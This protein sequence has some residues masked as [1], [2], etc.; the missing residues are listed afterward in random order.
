MMTIIAIKM[1]ELSSGNQYGRRLSRDSS[2]AGFLSKGGNMLRT[3]ANAHC[4]F[5]KSQVETPGRKPSWLVA[6][7]RPPGRKSRAFLSTGYRARFWA[8]YAR[9]KWVLAASLFFLTAVVAPAADEASQLLQKL[10]I[11]FMEIFDRAAPTVVVIEADKQEVADSG[12]GDFR[13]DTRDPA[14]KDPL[15]QETERSEGSGFIVRADGCIFTN[16]HVIENAQK[17]TVRLK[18]GRTLP[19]KVLGADDKTDIAVLKIDAKDLPVVQFAD[20]D[21]VRVGQLACSIGVPFKLDYSFSC[22]WVSA[23]G[24]SKL[25]TTTYEDYIQT[26]A[27]INPGNSGGPLLDVQGRVIGMNTLI[28]GLGSGVAFAIPSNMLQNVGDQ[29]MA[30]GKVVRAWLGVRVQSLDDTDSVKFAHE[31]V[32]KGVLVQTIEPN[33]P[34]FN[35][36]LRP[37]DI[38]TE[39]DGVPVAAARDLQHEILKRK[40]GQTVKLSVWREEKTLTIAVKTGELPAQP[41]PVANLAPAIKATTPRTDCYGVSLQDLDTVL[42]QSLGAKVPQGAIVTDVAE[43]SP[44]DLAGLQKEDVLTEIDHQPVANTAEAKQL[45]Q[46]PLPATGVLIFI[47]RHGQKAF[48][49]LRESS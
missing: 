27:F 3:Q 7:P 40:V 30:T 18:D 43:D 11:G 49:V 45:L 19:A 6:A 26:D 22:G 44:A 47:D 14:D 15:P 1:S 41:R 31:G 13:F 46:R 4:S 25:T 10:N 17:I 35:S 2:T 8:K 36:D 29:L 12:S 24:R 32:E 48:V 21:A 37:A 34:A 38:I 16:N 5:V 28:N 20:S 42:A 9:M 33:T 23:K 39:L